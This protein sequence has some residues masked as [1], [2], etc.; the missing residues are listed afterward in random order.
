MTLRRKLL[1]AFG[2]LAALTLLAAA[3]TVYLTAR[4]QGATEEMRAHYTRSLLLQTVRAETFQALA[5]VNDALAGE[6]DDHADA[7]ADFESAISDTDANFAEWQALAGDLSETTEVMEVRAAYE[8]LTD[9]ARQVFDLIEAGQREEA[10]R[11]VDDEL[12]TGDYAQF[13]EVTELA[14]AADARIR[15]QVTAASEDLRVTALVMSAVI[16][17]AALS[18][19]LL[20]AA[21]LAQDVF[22][23]LSQLRRG[24]E[25][26]ASGDT[27]ERLPVDREDEFGKVAAA[28]NRTAETYRRPS[29]PSVADGRE[30]EGAPAASRGANPIL[31][32]AASRIRAAIHAMREG[33]PLEREKDLDDLEAEAEGL[34]KAILM[35]QPIGLKLVPLDPR[36]TAQ[37]AL[38]AV[39][40]LMAK[41]GISC[42]CEFE[43]DEAAILADRD[44]LR[45]L[46]VEV[47]RDALSALPERG[48]RVG[49]RV[50][51]EPKAGQVHIDVATSGGGSERAGTDETGIDPSRDERAHLRM[52]RHLVSEHGG[53]FELARKPGGAAVFHMAFP[54]RA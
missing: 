22:Q 23:P 1:I 15:E 54:A 50:R 32:L 37:E 48:G 18:L 3:V 43:A 7:R 24:L 11:L 29:R 44:R 4:W 38:A 51:G 46:I 25:R 31:H 6:P 21:Y 19:T 34:A 36:R 42:E 47:L 27:G 9:Y 2:G 28:F 35:A 13:Q 8:R 12:D 20:I 40:P 33:D 16:I 10:V 14:V 39:A 45:D 41:R 53:E 5:E 17:I 26:L 49:L 52:M 30:P